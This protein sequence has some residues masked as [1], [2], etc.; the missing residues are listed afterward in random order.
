MTPILK[1][2]SYDYYRS[3]EVKEKWCN[4]NLI[5]AKFKDVVTENYFM[6]PIVLSSDLGSSSL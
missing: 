5:E 3:R 1:I 4:L 6:S 2:Y